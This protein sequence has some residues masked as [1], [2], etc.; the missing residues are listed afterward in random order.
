MFP[1]LVLTWRLRNLSL[2]DFEATISS[3]DELSNLQDSTNGVFYL[4]S[5]QRTIYCFEIPENK[6]TLTYVN[7][8]L[9]LLNQNNTAELPYPEIF[10][11][12]YGLQHLVETICGMD[13]LVIG[14]TE[15]QG[16]FK[17][18]FDEYTSLMNPFL[19]RSISKIIQ[20]GKTIRTNLIKDKRISTI[21]FI[22]SQEIDRFERAESIGIIGT[23]KMSLGMIRFLKKDHPKLHVYTLT[24]DRINEQIQGIIIQ[25][26]KKIQQHDIIITASDKEGFLTRD[27]METHLDKNNV[28]IIDLG[29]PRNCSSDLSELPHVTIKLLKDYLNIGEKAFN[30][31]LI[32]LSPSIS[33]EITKVIL[34]Y[35]NSNS[36]KEFLPLREKI[37]DIYHAKKHDIITRDTID[38]KSLDQLINQLIHVSQEHCIHNLSDEV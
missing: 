3:N 26:I 14:E 17:R 11:G 5:C 6:D 36:R 16:Q 29:I 27:F 25:D 9:S 13:S 23:G 15:I 4:H 7:E 37:L 8:I 24:S 20:I 21:S 28:F 32:R 19:N 22:K 18:S 34:D 35:Q 2:T 10:I 38:Q 33:S 12:I 30:Q 31:E 1:L